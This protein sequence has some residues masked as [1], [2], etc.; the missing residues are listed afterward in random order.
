MSL[1]DERDV[2]QADIGNQDGSVDEGP[3]A[4]RICP[5]C[6]AE[7]TEYFMIGFGCCYDCAHRAGDC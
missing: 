7:T 4:K 6:G 5:E 1:I 2:I 3:A